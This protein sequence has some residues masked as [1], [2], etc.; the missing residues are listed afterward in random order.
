M[1]SVNLKS[2]R[3][4]EAMRMPYPGQ[5][6]RHRLA[7]LLEDA[8]LSQKLLTVL[9]VG[10]AVVVFNVARYWWKLYDQFDKATTELEVL[11]L[12]F[13]CVLAL[14]ALIWWWDVTF[15]GRSS[16]KG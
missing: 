6:W 7:G 10:L 11:K 2:Q 14:I 5:P 3:S 9:Y 16:K 1:V 15:S 4:E 12:G 13:K 8:L